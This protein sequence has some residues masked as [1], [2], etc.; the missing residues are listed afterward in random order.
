MNDFEELL[1]SDRLVA[2]ILSIEEAL[3]VEEALRYAT[4]LAEALRRM[5]RDGAVCGCLDPNHI[6]WNESGV[7]LVQNGAGGITA[8]LAPEQLRGETVDARS[9]IFAFGAIFY[10]LLSGGK[11]FPARD[12]EELTKEILECSP[13]PLAGIPTGIS[14]LVSRCLEKRPENRW[15]RMNS[16]VIELKLANATTRRANSASEWKER[17]NSLWSQVDGQDERLTAY[18]AAQESVETELRQSLQRLEEKIGSQG[19]EIAKIHESA[20]AIQGS[21][22]GLQN[23]A[24]VHTRAIEGLEAAASQ[25]DEVVEHIVEAFGVM[26]K[27]MVERGEAKV[28]LVARDGS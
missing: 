12:P 16:I 4:S 23:G 19:T 7:K 1:T 25:T 10:E 5:H 11:A 13:A 8:Y 18:R 28:L 2:D 26:H 3:P 20:A 15:Q 27:S 9:D 17:V 14:A 22:A 6:V 21:I 24:Q